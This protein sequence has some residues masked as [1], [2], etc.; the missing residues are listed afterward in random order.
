LSELETNH[1][2]LLAGLERYAL[3]DRRVTEIGCGSAPLHPAL[4]ARG[5][6]VTGVELQPHLLD[7]ARTQA[8]RIDAEQRLRY[9]QG[10]F[11]AIAERVPAADF[12]ILDKAVHCYGEPELLVRLAARHARCAVAISFPRNV[13][14]LRSMMSIIGPVMRWLPKL[15]ELPFRVRFTHPDVVRRWL[16]DEG[17]RCTCSSNAGP[18]HTEVYERILT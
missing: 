18:W 5:A 11:V 9:V 1:R 4:L 13:L 6:H 10:D 14:W 7:R 2:Q 15:R 16:R 12:V 17:L 8:E 3:H